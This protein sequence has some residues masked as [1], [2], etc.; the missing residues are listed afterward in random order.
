MVFDK[1][2]AR[3]HHCHQ[4]GELVGR[5]LVGQFGGKQ[6]LLVILLVYC[7][8]HLSWPCQPWRPFFSVVAKTT[9]RPHSL[10]WY[11]VLPLY[12][13]ILSNDKDLPKFLTSMQI[14]WGFFSPPKSIQ[15]FWGESIT[16]LANWLVNCP[17]S[18]FGSFWGLFGLLEITTKKKIKI[19]ST[20]WELF[21]VSVP[22]TTI[23]TRIMEQFRQSKRR[24]LWKNM[25]FS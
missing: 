1:G 24:N 12:Y 2:P 13:S 14:L 3:C 5:R 25:E 11:K 21:W 22:K 20:K 23:M 16:R 7:L 19:I 10:H 4:A 15:N 9:Q 17:P 18:C 8:V 6:P